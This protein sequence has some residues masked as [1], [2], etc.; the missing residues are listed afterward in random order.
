MKL[1]KYVVMSLA[2]CKNG[3]GVTPLLDCELFKN[4][5]KVVT[6]CGKEGMT[7]RPETQ[8]DCTV[9]DRG[10]HHRRFSLAVARTLGRTDSPRNH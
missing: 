10:S 2:L 1:N 9:S 5:K 4:T 6:P 3:E 8:N 7:N